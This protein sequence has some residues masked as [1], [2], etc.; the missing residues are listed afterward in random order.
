MHP[1]IEQLLAFFRYD[2]L[3]PHLQA[4]SKP[5]AALA[6]EMVAPGGLE[7]NGAE[8]TVGLRKLLEAKDCFVRAALVP[9]PVAV[10]ADGTAPVVRGKK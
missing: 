3:P 7:L 6:H 5:F 10:P 8:A 9:V 4:V 1:A 2:H